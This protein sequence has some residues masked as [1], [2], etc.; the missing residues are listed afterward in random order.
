MKKIVQMD[1]DCY[2]EKLGNAIRFFNKKVFD[3]IIKDNSNDNDIGIVQFKGISIN[4]D[5]RIEIMEVT[6]SNATI[7]INCD[8]LGSQNPIQCR[9]PIPH[10][11]KMTVRLYKKGIT[12]YI[13]YHINT[14]S[15]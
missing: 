4:H 5:R 15:Q 3:D 10:N 12:K 8:L 11:N 6:D 13:S 1:H 14:Y 7:N 2:A 9:I